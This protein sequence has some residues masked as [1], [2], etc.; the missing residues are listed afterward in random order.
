MKKQLL[1]LYE[2]K[3]MEFMNIVS[4]FPE[5]KLHGP[6]LISPSSD[7]KNQKNPLLIVGQETNGWT[8]DVDNLESQMGMYEDFNVGVYYRPSPFW[9]VTRKV[10]EALGNKEYSCAWTN[11]SKFDVDDSR[12]YG[13]HLEAI[14]KVDDLLLD[15]IKILQ[16]K[17]CIFFTGP[18]FD[19]R[20]KKVFEDVEY[21]EVEG[22][23][24]RQLCQLKHKD[25]PKHSYRTHHPKSLRIRQLENDFIEFIGGINPVEV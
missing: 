15:E 23:P 22:W 24:M 2:G 21:L 5:S 20:I 8:D 3:K 12:P 17:V 1:K 11:V 7:Y 9:N 25:L 6:F 4:T 18:D 13:K 19:N 14:S 16:P 10:E